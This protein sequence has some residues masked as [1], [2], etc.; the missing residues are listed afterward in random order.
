[1]RVAAITSPVRTI[2]HPIGTSSCAMA[3]SASRRA[4]LM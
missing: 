3:R 1:L 4:S 2:T